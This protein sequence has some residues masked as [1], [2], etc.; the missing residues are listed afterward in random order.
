[1]RPKTS[2]MFLWVGHS[3]FVPVEDLV[4]V[5]EDDLVLALHALGQRG[6]LEH[7]QVALDDEP[8]V[9]HVVSL[10]LDQLRDHEPA[11]VTRDVYQSTWFCEN[12]THSA[13]TMEF[14]AQKKIIETISKF[15]PS[16]GGKKRQVGCK[17]DF[18]TEKLGYVGVHV[19][20]VIT[21]GLFFVS[22]TLE[23]TELTCACG[24]S[25]RAL[26]LPRTVRRRRRLTPAPD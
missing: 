22:Q 17:P 20:W 13:V 14:L 19:L 18:S 4:D 24:D 2:L 25:W 1:M 16:K 21:A 23:R 15:L 6:L 9:S 11:T 7:G 26:T 10:R 12:W 8:Q 3:L 5:A